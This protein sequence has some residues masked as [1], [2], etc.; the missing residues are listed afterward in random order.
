MLVFLIL[1]R[2]LKYLW[3]NMQV[4]LVSRPVGFHYFRQERKK[5][6]CKSIMSCTEPVHTAMETMFW[7]GGSLEI[8]NSYELAI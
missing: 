8:M 3:P 7:S 4:F 1:G 2:L 6:F 5:L